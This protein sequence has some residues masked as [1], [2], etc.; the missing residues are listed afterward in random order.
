MWAQDGSVFLGFHP[1]SIFVITK[2]HY[3]RFSPKGVHHLILLYSEDTHHWNGARSSLFAKHAIFYQCYLDVGVKR[4]NTIFFSQKLASQ[5]A[6]PRCFMSRAVRRKQGHSC[7]RVWVLMWR[8]KWVWSKDDHEWPGRRR[9]SVQRSCHVVVGL[10]R[11]A[12][13]SLCFFVYVIF[14]AELIGAIRQI[15]EIPLVVL[16][17]F[18]KCNLKTDLEKWWKEMKSVQNVHHGL[19]DKCW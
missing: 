9:P 6:W 1:N 13:Q 15:G 2:D 10:W 16:A 3:A 8:A 7:T 17:A 19:R 4:F 5:T 18:L 12:P 11:G 14:I